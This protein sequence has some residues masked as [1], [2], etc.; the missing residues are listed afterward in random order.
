MA[1]L[2]SGPIGAL[3]AAVSFGFVWYSTYNDKLAWLENPQDVFSSHGITALVGSICTGL[4]CY[5]PVNEATLTH[6]GLLYGGGVTMVLLD[7]AAVIIV[8]LY[9]IGM[10]LLLLYGLKRT[11]GIDGL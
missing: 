2:V 6:N 1:A 5:I 9:S 7:T 4:F 10:T 11:L 8:S 3:S